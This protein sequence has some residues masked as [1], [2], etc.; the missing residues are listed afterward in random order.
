V[1]ESG[2]GKSTL[3]RAMTGLAPFEGRLTFDGRPISGIADMDR[4]YR[5]DV[6][7]V[8]QH[9]DASLNPRHRVRDILARPFALYGR[10]EG[11]D[12]AQAVA[13]LLQAVRLSPGHADRFPHQ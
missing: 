9:P 12:V 11:R 10:P 1:G 7:I 13:D 3:A 5:R 2:S 6:Q 4:A 8:F